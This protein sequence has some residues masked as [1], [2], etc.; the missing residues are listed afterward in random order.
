MSQLPLAMPLRALARRTDPPTSH[1]A[2]AKVHAETLAERVVESLRVYGPATSDELAVR[3]GLK[4]VTVSP[5]L[6][7]LVRAFRVHESGKRAGKILWAI[8]KGST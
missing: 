2:A 5:R 4:L 7:P 8:G 1:E 3:L 6:R